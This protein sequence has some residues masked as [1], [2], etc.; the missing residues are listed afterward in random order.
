MDGGGVP[1][2]S[3]DLL[4]RAR[5]L[6][7][8]DFVLHA[9]IA[10]DGRALLIEG[11]SGIGKTALLD[12]ACRRA[13]SQGITVLS[14]RGGELEAQY[15]FGAVRQLFEPV[16]HRAS[17]ET[18]AQLLAGPARL[19][20]PIVSGEDPGSAGGADPG[21]AHLHGLYWL[22][23]N[24]ATDAPVLMVTVLAT[25]LLAGFCVE[26]TSNRT[27]PFRPAASRK[28][29]LPLSRIWMLPELKGNGT[30]RTVTLGVPVPSSHACTPGT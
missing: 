14:A 4:E 2:R 29:G 10:G 12:A 17:S 16:V 27:E 26:L 11:P 15:P 7:R 5:E 24:L 22:T 25:T 23:V 13:K 9:A 18:R 30:P 1:T 8:I 6:E 20:A 28:I 3:R 21:F 19:C